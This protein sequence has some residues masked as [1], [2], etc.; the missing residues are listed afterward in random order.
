MILLGH[1][2]L[3]RIQ[4]AVDRKLISQV[5]LEDSNLSMTHVKH[6]AWCDKVKKEFG[7][8]NC[9]PE[10][11]IQTDIGIFEVLNDGLVRKVK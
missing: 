9:D 4:I 6:D 11:R 1:E 8:C 2:Y 3:R 10:I 7:I 5:V